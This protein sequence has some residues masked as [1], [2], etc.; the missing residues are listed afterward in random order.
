MKNFE[1]FNLKKKEWIIVEDIRKK[2]GKYYDFSLESS[3]IHLSEFPFL[4]E[5]FKDLLP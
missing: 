3:L 1:N 5:K 4:Q 2:Q